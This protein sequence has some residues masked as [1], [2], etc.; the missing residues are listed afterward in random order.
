M[1]SRPKN[2]ARERQRR[3]ESTTKG[4]REHAAREARRRARLRELVTVIDEEPSQREN[5]NAEP[6]IQTRH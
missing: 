1:I 3:Y 5:P 6:Q 2:P 4:R